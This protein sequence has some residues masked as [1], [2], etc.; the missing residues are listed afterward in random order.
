MEE[1]EYLF[2]GAEF[3]RRAERCSGWAEADDVCRS[4]IKDFG[5]SEEKMGQDQTLD[6][7]PDLIFL[8]LVFWINKIIL[9]GLHAN[10]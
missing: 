10:Y 1:R 4:P 8:K 5:D 7:R 3:N 6:W 9:S 2:G